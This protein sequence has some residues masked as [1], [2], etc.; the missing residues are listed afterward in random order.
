MIKS[1][2]LKIG[3]KVILR[4]DLSYA[5]QSYNGQTFLIGMKKN[6]TVEIMEI[7]EN[8]PNHFAIKECWA[9][10]YAIEMIDEYRTRTLWKKQQSLMIKI[11]DLK[12]GTQI[13]L[14]ENIC[15]GA[16]AELNN[17]KVTVC[18]RENINTDRIL[19]SFEI[20]ETIGHFHTNLINAEKTRELWSQ[21]KSTD[22][23]VSDHTDFKIERFNLLNDDIAYLI[24]TETDSIY[25]YNIKKITIEIS[26]NNI[27]ITLDNRDDFEKYLDITHLKNPYEMLGI[28]MKDL[29][30]CE[31]EGE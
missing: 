5:Q 2:E 28:M 8:N 16:Y 20:E 27:Y 12:D 31:G 29:N 9:G 18:N 21:S 7:M 17:K 25:M 24:Q 11:E 19:N 22:S 10:K 30:L 23:I 13:I 15:I 3:T 4:D 1:E 6:C 14:K 26:K